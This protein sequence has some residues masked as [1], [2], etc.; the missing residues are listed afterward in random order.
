MFN[1]K[2]RL[3]SFVQLINVMFCRFSGSISK[4][5]AFQQPERQFVATSD[6]FVFLNEYYCY[7]FTSFQQVFAVSDVS[8]SGLHVIPMGDPF[9]TKFRLN[10]IKLS[11][12]SM[13]VFGLN[14][15]QDRLTRFS[16]KVCP[17]CSGGD[18]FTVLKKCILNR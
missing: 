15:C 3:N 1:I 2:N 8:L 7:Y 14:K 13:T 6:K 5:E 11:A 9:W 17:W 16:T 4:D 18:L 12:I 10:Q